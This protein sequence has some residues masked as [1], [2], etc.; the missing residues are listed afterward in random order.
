MEE[1]AGRIALEEG[2]KQELLPH[3][4]MIVA[5]TRT[6]PEFAYKLLKYL[7]TLGTAVQDSIRMLDVSLDPPPPPAFEHYL[8][9]L[10][11]FSI[12]NPASQA[13]VWP[14]A[15]QL[16]IST[17][18][19]LRLYCLLLSTLIVPSPTRGDWF[20]DNEE[21]VAL[22][23][24]LLAK[25]EVMEDETFEWVFVLMRSV[26]PGRLEQLMGIAKAHGQEVVLMNYVEGLME[27]SWQA[28]CRLFRLQKTDITALIVA[29]TAMDQSSSAFQLGMSALEIS[30]RPGLLSPETLPIYLET[31]FLPFCWTTLAQPSSP[32][33]TGLKTLLVQ[34]LCNTLEN[35]PKAAD[36]AL[37]HLY[38]LL[39]CTRIEGGNLY[40]REWVVLVL[41][42]LV[43]LKPETEER[44][45]KL[46]IQGVSDE[47]RQARVE[48]DARTLR[49]KYTNFSSK[50]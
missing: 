41:K 25:L 42:F 46:E 40:M 22:F 1:W 11:N 9:F 47:D 26:L 49:P 2:L 35:C 14:V 20:T 6:Q 29:V 50:P 3:L 27:K 23:S 38:L 7:C 18:R 17:E 48:L 31:G 5:G 28:D 30:A 19:Q 15:Q 32:A 21:G 39:S 13:L 10:N 36:L 34:L 43:G 44:I 16:V 37:D 12:F 4:D 8:Q 24:Y 33:T 45:R